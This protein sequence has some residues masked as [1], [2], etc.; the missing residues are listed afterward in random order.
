MSRRLRRV[1]LGVYLAIVL[2]LTLWP[3]LRLPETPV[4]RPDLIGHAGMFGL[5]TFLL[6][7]ARV[8]GAPTLGARNILVGGLIA[9]VFA[10]ATEAAQGIPGVNRYSG[11]D[12]GAAN[13]LGVLAAVSVC[14]L[15]GAFDDQK[16]EGN[17][18]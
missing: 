1:L 2:L 14:F 10:T 17:S 15:G 9:L 18:R 11:W 16:R 4:P 6:V 5:L 3:G 13:A 12:D 7:L 8:G